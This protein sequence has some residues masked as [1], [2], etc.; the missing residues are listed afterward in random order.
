[1]SA[2]F[3]PPV[4]MRFQRPIDDVN[5]DFAAFVR[6]WDTISDRPFHTLGADELRAKLNQLGRDD[7]PARPST[8]EVEDR[9][10][11]LRNRRPAIRI[12]RHVDSEREAPALIYFRGGGWII[13]NLDSHDPYLSFFCDQSRA[14]IISVD[15]RRAPEHIHPAQNDDAW[16]SFVWIAGRAKELGIDRRRLGMGGDSAGAQ[17]TAATAIRAVRSEDGPSLAFLLLIYPF[18]DSDFGR[19]SHWRFRDG[20]I[21][22]RDWLMWEWATWQGNASTSDALPDACPLREPDLS[23]L[24]PSSLFVA[25]ADPL[26]DEGAQFAHRLLAA[27]V[28]TQLNICRG[29]PHG[30]M[31][32]MFESATARNAVNQIADVLRAGP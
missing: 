4:G 15:Y 8:V 27:G 32:G 31:R 29:L 13:G 30:F 24:P 17:L 26:L 1:M 25:G 28:P 12:Y 9:V 10:I 3:A 5:A 21:L 23:G 2:S 16:D 20:P 14:T 7:I 22:T 6:R 19:Y 18:F 11:D